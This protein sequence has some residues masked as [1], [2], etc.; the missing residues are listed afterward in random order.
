[1]INYSILLEAGHFNFPQIGH[2]HFRATAVTAWCQ[3]EV[4]MSYL[5]GNRNV[6]LGWFNL[7]RILALSARRQGWSAAGT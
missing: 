2:Y 7:A 4:K 1:M 5:A 3:R 6:L